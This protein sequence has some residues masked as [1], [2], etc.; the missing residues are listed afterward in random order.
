MLSNE[1]THSILGK[2]SA[3]RTY[4]L[5][6]VSYDVFG[7]VDHREDSGHVYLIGEIYGPKN[8]DHTVS[9]LL[10]YLMS[11]GSVPRWVKQVQIFLDNSGS[12]NKKQYLM[13]SVYE[14]V[15]RGIFN[16]ISY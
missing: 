2:E 4:Y 13:G 9:Y 3:A 5:Q 15:E 10:H 11:T 1:L 14:I 7:I 16:F 6:K 12:T 8:T